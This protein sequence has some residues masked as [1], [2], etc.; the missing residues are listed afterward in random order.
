MDFSKIIE[1]F[2]NHGTSFVSITQQF[3]TTTSKGRLTL[4][5][6]LFFT[7]FERKVTG[8][9]IRDKFATSAKKGL[10]ITGATPLG[11]KK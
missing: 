1:I 9:R 2:D 5:I 8:K 4:N 11:Y 6:L 7:Q 3:N 10:W